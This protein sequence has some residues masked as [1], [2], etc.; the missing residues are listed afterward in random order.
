MK[1]KI[2][3][4]AVY[5]FCNTALTFAQTNVSGGIYS[6]TT[7]TQANSPYIVTGNI[8]LFP[9][10]I[11]T[12]EPG[13][14]V[15]F[16]GNYNIEIRGKLIAIG[17]VND[18][19]QFISNISQTKG[20][21]YK[22][23]ILNASQN[24]VG[25]FEYCI[26]KHS[27][28]GIA[29]ECCWGNDSSYIKNS[30]FDNNGVASSS[31]AGWDLPIDN[32]VF[33]NNTTAVGSA[34]KKVTNSTFT[35]NGIGI[36]CERFEARNCYFQNNGSAIDF[37]YG[38]YGTVDSCTVI[39]NNIGI[40]NHGPITNSNISNNN[41]GIITGHTSS[42][43][44]GIQYYVSIKNNRIC[45]NTTYNVENINNYNK[46]ITQNCFCTE[47]YT[48]IE[49]KLKDGYDDIALGLFNYDIYDST[50]QTVIQ[51]VYK[52]GGAPSTTNSISSNTSSILIFPNPFN[53]FIT[54]QLDNYGNKPDGLRI[55][56]SLGQ[57]VHQLEN[58]NGQQKTIDSRNLESGIYLLQFIKDN[59]IEGQRKLIKE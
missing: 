30:L 15:K 19:I 40:R 31:Y 14:A 49:S 29:V 41:I 52:I 11:L 39:N 59:N 5:I 8:V 47:D 1:I 24:A 43:V 42:T 56:N 37:Y 55:Y 17:T 10:K 28:N 26:V 21:W 50:C 16:N 27:G 51:S 22:I 13:T 44:N 2:S 7:W 54:I 4:L 45:N 18:S 23:Q 36:S 12:I 53:D 32:C 48:T 34:D 33:T 6:N 38:G 25:F 58:I 35:N 57:K 20:A 3:F 46:D 9:N